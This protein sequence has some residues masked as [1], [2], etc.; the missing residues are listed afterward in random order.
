MYFKQRLPW[1]Y[2]NNQDLGQA[3]CW[4]M[5]LL[6]SISIPHTSYSSFLAS[7]LPQCSL[8][9]WPVLIKFK[10]RPML[11]TS[12]LKTSKT[13][14]PTPSQRTTSSILVRP[15]ATLLQ[16]PSQNASRP[17]SACTLGLWFRNLSSQTQWLIS[18]PSYRTW[19]GTSSLST[20]YIRQSWQAP[21]PTRLQMFTSR[22][23]SCS[24]W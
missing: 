24:T 12:Q 22:S 14:G 13:R 2:K 20:V 19:S 18:Q 11:G 3:S 16:M 6:T 1:I 21:Q 4:L 10:L 8:I 9:L 17:L 7:R 5:S 15:S 23:V